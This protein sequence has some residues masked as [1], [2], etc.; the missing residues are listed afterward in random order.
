M[1][2]NILLRIFLSSKVHTAVL[3]MVIWPIHEAEAYLPGAPRLGMS[4]AVPVLFPC[5]FMVWEGINLIHPY[6]IMLSVASMA[7]N[8]RMIGK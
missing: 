8:D 7:V 2:P 5:A 1:G 3:K 6:L 4:G